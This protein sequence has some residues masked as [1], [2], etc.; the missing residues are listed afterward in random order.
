MLSLTPIIKLLTPK[1]A[2]FSGLWFRKVG[3][4]AEYAQARAEALPLPMCWVVRFAD[5]ASPIGEA[6]LDVS[7]AF[8]VVIAVENMRTRDAGETDDLL[9]RYRQAVQKLLLGASV[10][11]AIKPINSKG[12]QMIDYTNQDLYYRDRYQLD[13]VITNY[14]PDPAIKPYTVDKNT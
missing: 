10:P 6:A 1:P 5:P 14:L 9:L 3:G 7:I 11:G 2:D 12:G 8:D 13:A 4:A